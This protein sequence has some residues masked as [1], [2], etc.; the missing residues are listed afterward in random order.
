MNQVAQSMKIR[1]LGAD[2]AEAFSALRREVTRDNPVPMGLAFDEELTRTLDGF[3]AQLSSPLPNAVFGSFVEGEL[4]GT[5]AVSRAGPFP[6]S[7]H[8]MV[9][10]GVFTSPRYR[11]RGLSRQVV[12]AAL[13]HAFDNGVRRVNLQVYVP[14]EPAI[15]LYKAIG[16]V[17]YGIESEAVCLD[18]QYHD[19]VHMTL[20]K[21]RHNKPLHPTANDID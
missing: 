6:S 1:R 10:W 14:N 5:A 21:S 15:T 3:R 8:K 9:M 19:G 2:D 11:R 18:G 12:E 13:Q 4:A 20:V 16:F 7:H 17:E